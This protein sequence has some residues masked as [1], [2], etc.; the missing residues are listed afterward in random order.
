MQDEIPEDWA[1][2]IDGVTDIVGLLV[3]RA[4]PIQALE[5]LSASTAFVLCNLMDSAKSSDAAKQIFIHNLGVAVDKA[6]ELGATM[7]TRGT[8]H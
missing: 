6:E 4:T 2:I 5:I 7:W 3:E 8:S 1:V